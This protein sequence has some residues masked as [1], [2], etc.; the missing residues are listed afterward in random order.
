M[1]AWILSYY[2]SRR[3]LNDKSLTMNA[4]PSNTGF[5]THNQR[6]KRIE[7]KVVPVLVG[8]RASRK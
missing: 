7:E 6:S 5:T 3:Q 2:A 1:M 4:R 8:P